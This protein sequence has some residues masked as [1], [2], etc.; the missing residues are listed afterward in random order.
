MTKMDFRDHNEVAR[1]AVVRRGSYVGNASARQ[2]IVHNLLLTQKAIDDV[3]HSMPG[4][5]SIEVVTEILHEERFNK[6]MDLASTYI[7]VGED[8][9]LSGAFENIAT[10]ILFSTDRCDEGF[11]VMVDRQMAEFIGNNP[12]VFGGANGAR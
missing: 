7:P 9:D 5:E 11:F 12:D 1:S 3:K 4:S 8:D 6:V 10:N 2:N